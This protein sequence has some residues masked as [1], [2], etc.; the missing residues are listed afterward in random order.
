VRIEVDHIGYSFSGVLRFSFETPAAG[1]VH[2]VRRVRQYHLDTFPAYK[3]LDI[4]HIRTIA[5]HK[6]VSAK[7][8]NIIL[9]D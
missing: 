5:A 3:P 8:P 6:F 1:I 7:L 4:A 2:F 9:L